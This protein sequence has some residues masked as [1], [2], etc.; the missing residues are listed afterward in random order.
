MLE[1]DCDPRQVKEA[2]L[3]ADRLKGGPFE[4][5]G[6]RERLRLERERLTALSI[7]EIDREIKA[8]RRR[9][10]SEARWV[11]TVVTLDQC[12]VWPAM[13]ERKWATGP[14]DRVAVRLQREGDRDNKV[15]KI[16]GVVQQTFADLPLT[17]FR[18]KSNPAQYRIDDGSHRAVAY[19]LA[20]FREAFAYVGRVRDELNHHWPWEG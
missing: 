4:P 1:T 13:D 18:R 10:L 2:L 7:V 6:F 8:D 19:Y 16:L 12:S 9:R 5:E 20:G 14:V 3:L 15:W 11:L 17:A